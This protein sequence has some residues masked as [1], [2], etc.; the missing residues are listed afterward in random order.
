MSIW[1]DTGAMALIRGGIDI[2]EVM[3]QM[4]HTDLSTTQK[5]LKSLTTVNTKIRD[6]ST[7]LLPIS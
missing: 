4:R 3:R 2:Y 7:I 6:L 1:K 5:Y